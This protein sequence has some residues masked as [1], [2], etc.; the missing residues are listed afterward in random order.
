MYIKS[1]VIIGM[2]IFCSLLNVAC[3]TKD[4]NNVMSN[5]KIHE[6]NTITAFELNK[7]LSFPNFTI[8]HTQHKKVQGPNNAKWERQ[9]F[10]FTVTGERDHQEISWS[11][12]V[13]RNTEFTVDGM[14]YEL[15]M[16]SYQDPN[17]TTKAFKTLGLNEL[18]IVKPKKVTLSEQKIKTGDIVFR[19]TKKKNG[20]VLFNEYGTIQKNT[21]GLFVWD[22]RNTLKQPLRSWSAQG[23]DKKIAIFRV[24]SPDFQ[25]NEMEL[26]DGSFNYLFDSEALELVTKNF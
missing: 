6:Y 4:K 14:T 1:P 24:K 23:I 9:T 11:T 18:I 8:E 17:S 5:Q 15:V 2:V 3:K 13:I 22:L 19:S 10:Y 25:M 20:E 12:G 26:I 16:G 21:F 7:E